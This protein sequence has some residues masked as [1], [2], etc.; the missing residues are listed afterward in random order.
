MSVKSRHPL[1][2][3]GCCIVACFAAVAY[4][5]V[6]M[7][8]CSLRKAIRPEYSTG[9]SSFLRLTSLLSFRKRPNPP[10]CPDPNPMVVVH[11]ATSSPRVC[12][13]VLLALLLLPRL[14][15][16]FRPRFLM[17]LLHSCFLLRLYSP[18]CPL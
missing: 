7:L 4:Q 6:Y 2:S 8:H 18:V 17:S 13:T 3:N 9:A 10:H 15:C 11:F 1:H 14:R 16:S 12:L 5:R